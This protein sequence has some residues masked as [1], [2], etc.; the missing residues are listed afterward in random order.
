MKRGDVVVATVP[1]AYGKPR[2]AVVVQSDALAGVDSVLI[3]LISSYQ[4]DAP[5]Y[6]L[7]CPVTDDTGLREPSDILVEKIIAIPRQKIGQTVGRLGEA[8]MIALNRILAFVLGLGDIPTDQSA[9]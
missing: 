8:E 7:P 5:L 4:S 9:S 1:G 3:A 2:P 6:R